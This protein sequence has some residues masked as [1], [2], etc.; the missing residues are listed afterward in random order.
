MNP[1]ESVAQLD[2]LNSHTTL[3]TL[4]IGGNNAYFGDVMNYCSQRIATAPKCQSVYQAAVDS[5]IAN[6]AIGST[7]SHDDYPDLFTAIKLK[8]PSAKVLVGG[9]PHLFPA[10]RFT[11]CN[12]GAPYIPVRVFDPTDMIWI[13]SEIDSLNSTIR[14]SATRAGF[15]Y[16]DLSDALKGHELCTKTPWINYVKLQLFS[17]TGVVWSTSGSYHPNATGQQQF[18]TAFASRL[19]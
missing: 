5:A 10:D 13:N 3:V 15:V 4:T 2:R 1:G 16:V 7:G 19:P 18:L 6:M 9:Y 11:S 12:T 14:Q 17:A 8:A